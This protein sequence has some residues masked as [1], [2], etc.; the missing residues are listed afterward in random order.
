MLCLSRGSELLLL[1]VRTT[2]IKLCCIHN[3]A[4]ESR[5]PSSDVVT[6]QW[7]LCFQSQFSFLLYDANE[8][9][10]FLSLK[11]RVPL[12]NRLCV[13]FGRRFKAA[14]QSSI[15]YDVQI[16]CLCHY[17]VN[18]LWGLD[19]N[20]RPSLQFS[21]DA[22]PLR[23]PDLDRWPLECLISE[24]CRCVILYDINIFTRSEVCVAACYFLALSFDLLTRSFPGFCYHNFPATG[25]RTTDQEHKPSV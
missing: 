18:K 10:G 17:A 19:G 5:H 6:R 7:S 24:T 11:C 13:W 12:R 9:P 23:S 3:I 25:K 4:S 2:N 14:G 16:L 1:S 8:H 22:H 21:G 15:C 20:T